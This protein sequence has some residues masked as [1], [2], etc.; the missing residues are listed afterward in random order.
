[1]EHAH[2]EHEQDDEP[3]AEG[4]LDEGDRAERERDSLER[5]GEEAGGGP[6]S[7]SGRRASREIRPAVSASLFGARRASS[8]CSDVASA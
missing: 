6:A 4:R 1:M 8:A 5:P 7:Q 3:E 2:P